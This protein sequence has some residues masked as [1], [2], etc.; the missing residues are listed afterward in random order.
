M[1][2]LCLHLPDKN[3]KWP[4]KTEVVWHFYWTKKCLSKHIAS[5][6][7]FLSERWL[8]ITMNL[9]FYSNI[10]FGQDCECVWICQSG[11]HVNRLNQHLC[12]SREPWDSWL[13]QHHKLVSRNCCDVL[14]LRIL[15]IVLLNLISRPAWNL[16]L[17]N[18]TDNPLVHA[19]DSRLSCLFSGR[20]KVCGAVWQYVGY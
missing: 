1:S 4:V 2:N 16:K 20:I 9:I 11:F 14:S 13:S 8:L 5:L 10:T 17:Q 7:L 15:P 6:T 19:W 18:P 12:M 3:F